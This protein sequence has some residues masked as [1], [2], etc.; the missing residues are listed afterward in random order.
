MFYSY[1]I[2]DGHIGFHFTDIGDAVMFKAKVVEVWDRSEDWEAEE[3]EEFKRPAVRSRAVTLSAT[4]N[5][6]DNLPKQTKDLLR[7][8][9]VKK[10]DAQNDKFV[11]DILVDIQKFRLESM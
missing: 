9:G 1:P 8:L 6:L 4:T 2:Q 5:V 11:Q 7:Q 3:E 10:S